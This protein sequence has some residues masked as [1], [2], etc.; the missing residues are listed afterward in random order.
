M[1]KRREQTFPRKGITVGCKTWKDDDLSHSETNENKTTSLG[2]NYS[3]LLLTKVKCLL[4]RGVGQSRG[5]R[6]SHHCG[7]NVN[8]CSFLFLCFSM[9]AYTFLATRSQFPDHRKRQV[10]TPGRPGN[11]SNR[12]GF[13][14]GNAYQNWNQPYSLTQESQIQDLP[15]RISPTCATR[16]IHR[17][18]HCN[19]TCNHKKYWKK[20]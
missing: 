11:S 5:S 13:T 8:R 16:S 17:V 20:T 2:Y 18:I 9:L 15:Y 19:V 10:L 3:S 4:T 7:G 1:S 14:K 6:R 12:C